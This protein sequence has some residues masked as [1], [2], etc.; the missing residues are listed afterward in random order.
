MLK[1]NYIKLFNYKSFS[2]NLLQGF[3]FS[4]QYL[5]FSGWSIK[6]GRNL[7]TRNSVEFHVYGRGRIPIGDNCLFDNDHDFRAEGGK[8]AGKY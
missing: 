5:F 1:M 8:F 4:T 7:T 2:F 6:L 3:P